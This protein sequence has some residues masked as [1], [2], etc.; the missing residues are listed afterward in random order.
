MLDRIGVALG[1][2]GVVLGI[3]AIR[4][5]SMNTSGRSRR[6]SRLDV[7]STIADLNGSLD[8][9]FAA[10]RTRLNHIE[11][12]LSRMSPPPALEVVG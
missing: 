2:G 9:R 7:E 10:V 12:Q 1:V 5:A 11:Y 8:V 3:T 4:Y 6:L